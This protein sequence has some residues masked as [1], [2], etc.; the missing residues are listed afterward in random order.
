M[1]QERKVI[2]IGLI[3]LANILGLSGQFDKMSIGVVLICIAAWLIVQARTAAQKTTFEVFPAVMPSFGDNK[4]EWVYVIQD[5]QVTGFCKIGRTVT[6]KD[7]FSL[8]DVKL[9]FKWQFV[10]LIPCPNSA[11]LEREIH[12]SYKDQRINGEWFNLTAQDAAILKDYA[13]YRASSNG[14]HEVAQS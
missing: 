8:F 4:C 2:I 13:S 14:H 9:P 12:R 11:S 7:R 10:A 3:V 6:P 5:I 1:N